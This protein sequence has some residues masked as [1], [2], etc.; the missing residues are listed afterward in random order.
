[1][2]CF[3]PITSHDFGGV[4]KELSWLANEVVRP[5]G[6]YAF[7]SRDPQEIVESSPTI[8]GFL[9]DVGLINH[10]RYI[11]VPYCPPT[12]ESLL[13]TDG[14]CL[15]AVNIPLLNCANCEYR[16][17]SATPIDK[18]PRAAK[19]GRKS[20]FVAEYVRYSDEDAR[21]ISR[22]STDQPLWINTSVPHKAI[23][24]TSLSRVVLT[25]RFSVGALEKVR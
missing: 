22:C 4:A 2:I 17:Y 18:A 14:K 19:A 13:H 20:D 12:S 7:N 3:A 11:G 6:R 15:E 23:N 8:K 1:M 24:P 10:L 9:S 21:E 16:W 25:M 5:D